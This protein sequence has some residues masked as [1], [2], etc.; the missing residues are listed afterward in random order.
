MEGVPNAFTIAIDINL[1]VYV[2]AAALINRFTFAKLT[3]QPFV[4]LE[5]YYFDVLYIATFSYVLYLHLDFK[6]AENIGMGLLPV[7]T[8]NL[9]YTHAYNMN[10]LSTDLN[11]NTFIGLMAF[12]GF[13]RVILSM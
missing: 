4:F 11:T 13:S 9:M 3:N 6:E 5:Y 10:Y 12:I 8:K 7:P 1:F 2:T